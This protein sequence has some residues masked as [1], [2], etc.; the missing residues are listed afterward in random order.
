MNSIDLLVVALLI[1]AVWNGWRQGAII[2]L[3]SL[4]GFFVAV[5]LAARFGAPLGRLCGVDAE[6]AAPAGFVLVLLAALCGVALLAR[7]VR[8]VVRVAG[9]G[10][11]DILLGI[12]F[13]VVKFLLLAAL[14]CAAFDR[15]NAD[16]ELVS[17]EKIH[18][19]S[20]YRPLLRLSERIF[21]FVDELRAEASETISKF[22]AD[23]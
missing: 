10:L 2:Q 3:C 14:L 12:A 11:A 9:L 23:A 1:V 16:L 13:S 5:W 4:A 21:P 15:L 18:A 8:K 17:Q 20:T 19:S 22:R 7:V 6:I